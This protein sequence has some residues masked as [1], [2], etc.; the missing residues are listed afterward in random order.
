[1]NLHFHDELQA[2]TPYEGLTRLLTMDQSLGSG[3]VTMGMV[4]LAPGFIIRPHT[5]LVEEAITILSGDLI[6]LVGEER[7]EVRGRRAT[8]VAPG[9]TVHGLRNIG[10]TDAV[11]CIAYPA[12]GVAVN[13]VDGVEL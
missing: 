13:L 5:H 3:A 1:M 8:F 4:T 7:T 6:V 11:L 2:V 9:N 10:S 12:V